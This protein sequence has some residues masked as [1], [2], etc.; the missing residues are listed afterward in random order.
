MKTA[1]L[2]GGA[3]LLCLALVMA[4]VL[5]EEREDTERMKA[6]VA[7]GGDWVRDFG[8]V[9]ECKGVNG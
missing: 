1:A 2:V 4:G 7:A 8:N 3:A 9:Y 5:L 6:C